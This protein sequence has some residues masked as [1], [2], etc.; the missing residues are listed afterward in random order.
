M[1]RDSD[2]DDE[3]KQFGDV[4]MADPDGYGLTKPD[5]IAFQA[6]QAAWSVSFTVHKKTQVEAETAT[7]KKELDKKQLRDLISGLVGKVKGTPGMTPDKLVAAGITPPSATRTP[8]G[9]PTTRPIG[10]AEPKPNH[11]SVVHFG[12]EMTPLKAAKPPGVHGCE[13]W[14]FVGAEPPASPSAYT[15]LAL[16]TRTPYT[17]MHD[18]ADA[19]KNAYYLLRWQNHK[20]ESGPWSDV[21]TI[22][23]PG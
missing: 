16:D 20:G 8:E 1:S 14:L 3:Q 10:R 17:D 15:F 21:I 5:V 22:K 7:K 6:G 13:V 4:V 11:G 2:F 12:D 18:A 23:I 9:V 19:G